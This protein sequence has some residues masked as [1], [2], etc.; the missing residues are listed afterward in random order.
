LKKSEFLGN[1]PELD[2]DTFIKPKKKEKSQAGGPNL[3][4]PQA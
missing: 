3:I 4:S 1:N 2:Y